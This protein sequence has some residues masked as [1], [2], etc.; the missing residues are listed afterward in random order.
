MGDGCFAYRPGRPAWGWSNAGLVV[1]DGAS[2]LVDTL[3][4][5]AAH[6]RDARGDGAAH[7][8]APIDVVVNTHANGDHCYG[9]QLVAGAEIIASAATAEEM[10]EVPPAAGRAQRGA[11]RG[12]RP[13]PQLLRRVPVRRH[14]ADACRRARSTAVSTSRSAGAG[15]AD[16][17]RP[18]A[19]QGRHHRLR[20]RRRRPSSPATSCSSTAR[21]SCGPGRCR[22]GSRPAT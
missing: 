10:A 14:R 1:G 7:R 13:V 2:L 11:R 20:A 19:H 18:G 16:R 22:T 6:G 21:R 12:R 9:N 4:D 15:R 17:G 8:G 3:F 5:L